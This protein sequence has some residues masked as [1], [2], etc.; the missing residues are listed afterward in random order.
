[1]CYVGLCSVISSKSKDNEVSQQR[2]EYEKLQKKLEGRLLQVEEELEM[3]R[4]QMEKQHK[5]KLSSLSQDHQR[6]LD[7]MAA[8][9]LSKESHIRQLQRELATVQSSK[10]DTQQAATSKEERL[11]ELQL[12]LRDKDWHHID[13]V[14][15][16]EAKISELE[17][18]LAHCESINKNLRNEF[19]C[20]RIELEQ[21]SKEKEGALMTAK[22]CHRNREMELEKQLG[23]L[24]GQLEQLEIEHRRREWNNRDEVTE[25]QLTVEKLQS[26][27]VR[28]KEE[29]ERQIAC[30]AQEKVQHDLRLQSM[31][32]SCDK[33]REDLQARMEDIERYKQELHLAIER[34]RS[35][36]RSKN[37]ME[38]DWQARLEELERNKFGHQEELLKTLSASR[39]EALVYCR[40]VEEKLIEQVKICEC[41]R[42]ER[43]I[44]LEALEKKGLTE[45]AREILNGRGS[46][47]EMESLHRQN[48]ELR[49]VIS[50]MRNEM[51]Q[52]AAGDVDHMERKNNK[53]TDANNCPK[54][55]LS[56]Y[57]HCLNTIPTNMIY[58]MG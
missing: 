44:A 15:T 2:G 22:E 52:L 30:N 51:E 53:E 6:K 17:G 8:T 33:L 27:L 34:E 14:N 58:Y 31:Q 13:T 45:I 29:G 3:E 19:D 7:E 10:E 48:Q 20:R 32:A 12:E 39:D 9:L 5:E 11:K 56:P 36:E 37:Q 46:T 26:E 4:Q 43:D 25:K 49:H 21:L 57:Y 42:E 38:L 55:Q 23:E 40:Q 16:L 35:L 1:V 47:S 41:I 24:R 50:Q 18:Q 54:S 28:V